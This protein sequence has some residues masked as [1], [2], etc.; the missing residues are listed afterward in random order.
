MADKVQENRIRRMAERQGMQLKKIRRIDPKAID[1]GHFTLSDRDGNP[2]S[3]EGKPTATA[4]QIEA[5]L[6]A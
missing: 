4:D 2:V 6:K 5:F 3:V 1:Y